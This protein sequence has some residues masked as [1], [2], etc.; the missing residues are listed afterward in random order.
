MK[1][2]TPSLS[3][4]SRR[5]VAGITVIVI[6]GILSVQAPVLGA[7]LGLFPD[8]TFTPHSRP[9]EDLA[10]FADYQLAADALSSAWTHCALGERLDELFLTD[11]IVCCRSRRTLLAMVQLPEG[12]ENRD[13][14]K[15]AHELLSWM[16][17]TVGVATRPRHDGASAIDWGR[18]PGDWPASIEPQ[19]LFDLLE[20]ERAMDA[21]KW[22]WVDESE[23]S[24]TLP[25]GTRYM[26][27]TA[28]DDE[29][30]RRGLAVLLAR[31]FRFTPHTRPYADI[32]DYV[33]VE[34]CEWDQTETQRWSRRLSALMRAR[35]VP[36]FPF[37]AQFAP[38]AKLLAPEDQSWMDRAVEL[39]TWQGMQLT[40]DPV[41]EIWI[42]M[43]TLGP[44]ESHDL[45]V[46]EQ[47]FT[48]AESIQRNASNGSSHTN[49]RSS[50]HD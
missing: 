10:P 11:P 16:C 14:I 23:A 40:N 46:I 17:T 18:F 13:W 8:G 39:V 19:D 20:I 50:S 31:D 21:A 29:E 37:L 22:A 47:V 4:R 32:A 36:R 42:E 28:R 30:I 2:D 12:S 6:G 41:S 7:D 43:V 45:D 3:R 25:A 1:T 24:G 44:G 48:A 5:C 34:G 27:D 35:A 38:A 33:S 15:R 9:Y 26:L 49:L